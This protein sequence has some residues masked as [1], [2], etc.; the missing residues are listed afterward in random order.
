LASDEKTPEEDVEAQALRLDLEHVMTQVLTDVE[1]NVLR[2]RFGLEDGTCWSVEET[3][4]QLGVSRDRIRLVE[5]RALNKLRHPQQ[6]YKLQSYV[7]D[8]NHV[9]NHHVAD[10]EVDSVS[11]TTSTESVSTESAPHGISSDRIWFF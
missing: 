8:S 10:T 7:G 9:W 6:N 3:A 1:Q 2:R 11:T 5:T 4:R